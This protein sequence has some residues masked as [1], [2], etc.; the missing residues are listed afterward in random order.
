[1]PMRSS[2]QEAGANAETPDRVLSARFKDRSAHIGIV[3]M[4]YVGLPLMLACT[5]KNLN[6]WFDIDEEKVENSILAKAL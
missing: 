3:G 5:T 1:M 2:D 6:A 4:G